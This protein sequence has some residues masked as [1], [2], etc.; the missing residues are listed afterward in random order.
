MDIFVGNLPRAASTADLER[1]FSSYDKA[2]HI[3]IK[4]G[5]DKDGN[6]FRYGVCSMESE[7]AALKAIKALNGHR[8]L[9]A[10]LTVHE[11]IHRNYSNERR[12]LGWRQREWEDEE[13]RRHERRIG[14]KRVEVDPFADDG[15][16]LEEVKP[17]EE[18]KITITGYNRFAVKHD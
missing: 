3:A 9:G 15:L 16:A 17:A 8:L 1:L 7:R 13:R 5:H 6:S 12:A 11:F 4:E 14:T 18:E 2:A 10:E